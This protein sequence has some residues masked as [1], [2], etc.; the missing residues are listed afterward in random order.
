VDLSA[1]DRGDQV[2]FDESLRKAQSKLQTLTPWL[3]QFTIRADGNSHNRHG[4]AL[5]VD[6][7]VEVVAAHFG[8][9]WT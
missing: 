4:V 2:A 9:R 7:N 8:A 3:K 6:G 1:L 5:A